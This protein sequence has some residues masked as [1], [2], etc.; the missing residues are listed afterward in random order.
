MTSPINEV[1]EGIQEMAVGEAWP[2]DIT[3]V[4]GTPTSVDSIVVTDRKN[5]DS[6]D[7]PNVITNDAIS[8]MPTPLDGIING[9]ILQLPAVTFST[10]GQYRVTVTF[11]VGA[12]KEISYVD[13]LVK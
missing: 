1:Q 6:S 5:F 4:N 7:E 3:S 13:I 10:A 12:R 8:T 9:D 11:F 2:F